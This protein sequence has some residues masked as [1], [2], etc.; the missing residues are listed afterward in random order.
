MKKITTILLT[1]LLGASLVGCQKKQIIVSIN[2]HD[3][4]AASG[5]QAEMPENATLKDLFDSF[6]GGSDFAYV[7]DNEGYIESING[8][9]ND[10]MGRWE[11]TLNGDILNDVIGNITLKDKDVCDVTYIPNESNPIVGGWQIAEVSRTDLTDEEAEIFTKAMAE[12]LGETY[13]SVCVLAEQVVSGKNYAYLARGTT[14]TPNPVSAYYIVKIYNDLNGNA[15]VQTIS[16]INIL[17]IQ[18]TEE[19]NQNLLGGWQITDS[20]RPGTLG[21]EEAQSSF[22][23]AMADVVG[24]IYNPIQLLASQVVN[25][26]NYIAL[27]RGR[28]TGADDVALYVVSWYADLQG[29][30]TVNEIKKLDLNYYVD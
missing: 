3:G 20:G 15:K 8:K 1:L 13:E 17:E 23:K 29:N 30:S 7:L 12:V 6:G 19:T 26:T 24:V 27:A 25:G 10:E 18:S 4:D 14:V 22:D 5:M 9:A 16:E 2:F 21:S 11:I 28:V